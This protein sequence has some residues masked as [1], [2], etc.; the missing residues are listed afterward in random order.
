MLN[1]F[2]CCWLL[3]LCRHFFFWFFFGATTTTCSAKVWRINYSILWPTKRANCNALFFNAAC[4][5]VWRRRRRR[6]TLFSLPL[7]LYIY[8]YIYYKSQQHHS[9][10][11]LPFF[12]F[13]KF[14]GGDKHFSLLR[15]HHKKPRNFQISI[16]F[17]MDLI[18]G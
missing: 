10:Q 4:F 15:P 8:I 17:N 9:G 14:F 7:F 1:N 5:P 6:R 13:R 16:L 3:A 18:F 12:F 2:L 11:Q